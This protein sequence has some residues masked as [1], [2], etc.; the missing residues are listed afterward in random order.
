MGQC[1]SPELGHFLKGWDGMAGGA[2][3]NFGHF[4]GVGSYWLDG[5]QK[6]GEA[7]N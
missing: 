3:R 5:K 6:S 4:F 2:W 7:P 1:D